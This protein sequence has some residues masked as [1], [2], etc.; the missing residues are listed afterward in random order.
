MFV[1][2]YKA[3]ILGMNE[4]EDAAITNALLILQP[5]AEEEKLHILRHLQISPISQRAC[6]AI[7]QERTVRLKV[8]EGVLE[9]T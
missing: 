9:A 7:L 8:V 4:E 1:V 3:S 6:D 5:L 2:I